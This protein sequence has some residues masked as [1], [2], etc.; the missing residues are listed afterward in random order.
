MKEGGLGLGRIYQPHLRHCSQALIKMHSLFKGYSVHVSEWK[1]L[2]LGTCRI[3]PLT[4]SHDVQRITRFDLLLCTGLTEEMSWMS[5]WPAGE[6]N[7]LT[8]TSSLCGTKEKHAAMARWEI[9]YCTH[10]RYEMATS[11]RACEQQ[12][13]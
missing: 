4:G 7:M 6:T 2:R 13:H 9:N 11:T 10:G 3:N 5:T 12:F 1:Q 8:V